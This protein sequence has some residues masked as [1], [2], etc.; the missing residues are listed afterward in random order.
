[1]ILIYINF[2]HQISIKL[3]VW[4]QSNLMKN[5]K[6]CPKIKFYETLLEL[7]FQQNLCCGRILPQIP[8]QYS[9]VCLLYCVWLQTTVHCFKIQNINWLLHGLHSSQTKRKLDPMYGYSLLNTLF[10]TSLSFFLS[11]R[12]EQPGYSGAG[13]KSAE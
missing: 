11:L 2:I 13:R 10:I 9:H 8:I 5:T 3:H 6:V 4:N 1:M 7:Y 12:F